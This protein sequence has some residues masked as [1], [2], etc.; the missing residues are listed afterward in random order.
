MPETTTSRG[1]GRRAGTALVV[2]GAVVLVL[3]VV[4]LVVGLAGGP[5]EPRKPAAP[6]AGFLSD[7]R[8]GVA[9]RL[10]SGWHRLP[11]RQAVRVQDADGRLG[12]SITTVA[13][14][15][16]LAGAHG[17]VEAALRRSLRASRVVRRW[18]GVVA[19]RPAALIALAG[20]NASGAV[21]HVLGATTTSRWRTYAVVVFGAPGVPAAELR[22]ARDIMRTLRF[23][24]PG[25]RTAN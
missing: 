6:A 14:R 5:D 23:G 9:L 15:P 18:R 21:L 17:E 20:R 10:P 22:E 12:L 16:D 1:A 19:G 7:R 4:G 11:G 3:A 13:S 25:G 8:F 24:R 2:I